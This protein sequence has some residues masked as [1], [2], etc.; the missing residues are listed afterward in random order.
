MAQP[1]TRTYRDDVSDALELLARV[2]QEIPNW[3]AHLNALDPAAPGH[4]HAARKVALTVRAMVNEAVCDTAGA[5]TRLRSS[6]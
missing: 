5:A 6:A 3:R 4:A 2:E 1:C